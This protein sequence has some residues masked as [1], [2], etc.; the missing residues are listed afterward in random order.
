MRPTTANQLLPS[1]FISTQKGR[2]PTH[3][4]LM[5]CPPLCALAAPHTQPKCQQ[6]KH[7]NI[8]SSSIFGRLS[9]SAA[10]AFSDPGSFPRLP[11]PSGCWA[12]FKV[13]PLFLTFFR[14]LFYIRYSGTG[15]F[16]SG[17]PYI[18][19]L[20]PQRRVRHPVA[21]STEWV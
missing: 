17:I 1:L 3:S 19:I 2:F 20:P 11:R 7:P 13:M 21:N 9:N 18:S 14:L 8:P 4:G 16:I 10:G 6:V 5:Q 15:S 12:N